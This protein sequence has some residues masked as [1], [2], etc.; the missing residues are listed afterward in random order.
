MSHTKFKVGQKVRVADYYLKDEVAQHINSSSIAT[1]N[2]E[3][4]DDEE[5]VCIAY[6]GGEMDFVPQEILE[7]INGTWI[8]Y[9]R[10]HMMNTHS[11]M[12]VINDAD[13]DNPLPHEIKGFDILF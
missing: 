12:I 13:L 11:G 5:L 4:S 10:N 2:S 6:K 1:I 7:V 3:P 9:D 8:I